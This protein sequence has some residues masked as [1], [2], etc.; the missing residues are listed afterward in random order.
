MAIGF[1]F[2]AFHLVDELTASENVE[3]PALL[4]GNDPLVVL[5]DEPTGNLDSA[6][7][8]DA[9]LRPG[10][11]DEVVRWHPRQPGCSGRSRGPRLTPQPILA[12][13]RTRRRAAEVLQ[14]ELA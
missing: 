1:V 5:A 14:A 2:Q 8:L 10:G 7:T 12:W 3:L 4:A 13:L 9:G 6:A 11:R